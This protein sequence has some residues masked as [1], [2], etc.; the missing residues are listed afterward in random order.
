MQPSNFHS[1]CHFCDGSHPP[2]DYVT[3]ALQQGFRA[4]GFSSHAPLPFYTNWNMNAGHMQRYIGEID[5]LKKTYR[6]QIEIYTGLEIDF[7]DLSYN[8]GIPY[9]RDLPLDYRIGSVHFLKRKDPLCEDNMTC[10]DGD[11]SEFVQAVQQYY[12]GSTRKIVTDFFAASMQMVATG[13]FDIVG[14]M[15][16]IY[17]NASYLPDFRDE[18]EWYTNLVHEYLLFIAQRQL[19]VEVNTKHFN[20]SRQTYPQ[21]KHLRLL[22]DLHIP[23]M[24]NSD[25]H[26]PHLIDDGRQAVLEM[27]KRVGFQCTRELVQ[28]QWQDV[29]I[30]S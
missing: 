20:R 29:P 6:N 8:A 17:M 18:D 19:V 12:G 15:D 11:P 24:V 26:S 2:E 16:K 22:Y 23:V 1:H 25:C 13:G 5:R 14:H 30:S 28:H 7:L 10:I 9:F 21:I 27:L 3:Q 4:Y